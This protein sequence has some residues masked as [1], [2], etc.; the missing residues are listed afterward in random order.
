M[1]TATL[2]PLFPEIE[3]YAVQRLEVGDGHVLYVEESGNPQ[4]VPVMVLHGGPGSGT[5]G[6][7][8]RYFDPQAY[9]IVLF[10]QRGAGKSTPAGCM[11]ANTTAHLIE[12]MELI[13]TRLKLGSVVLYGHSWGST[14]ALAYA[15]AHPAHVRGLIVGGIFLAREEDVA[16]FGGSRGSARVYPE[17]YEALAALIGN[18][19]EE[20]FFA[21]LY[22][23]LRGPDADLARRAAYA[24]TLYESLRADLAISDE[25]LRGDLENRLMFERALIECGYI[26]Q[27]C[28]L[29]ANQLLEGAAG[30]AHIPTII[31]QGRLD[32]VTPTA[33]AVDLHRALPGSEL[34]IL[35]LTGH[36][37]TPLFNAARVEAANA[38]LEKIA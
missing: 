10:D 29:R 13:R 17:E 19:P 6:G 21:A 12:D 28:F 33:G 9:R 8:R 4:G 27:G 11:E 14:L 16:W 23:V 36:W 2:T 1:N 31:L 18:P 20:R 25:D 5:W 15:E 30:I 38:M 7:Q 3:P 34:R 22:A 32:L 24:W 37:S 35:P 26:A